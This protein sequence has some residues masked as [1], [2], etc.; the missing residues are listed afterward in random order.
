MARV[1]EPVFATPEEAQ[2]AFYSAFEQA[3]I[4]AMMAVW[5]R[6]ED[7]ICVHPV[8]P[9]LEGREA[10]RDSWRALFRNSRTMKFKVTDRQRTQCETLAVYIVHENIRIGDSDT[11]HPPVV[12]TNVYRRTEAGWRMLLHH[13]SP[14]PD[15]GAAS[16]PIVH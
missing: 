6:Q 14:T 11:T 16:A 9:R 15:V 10:V 3:D 13:A 7:I 2:D 5:D 1:S 8:G 4:E 12:A